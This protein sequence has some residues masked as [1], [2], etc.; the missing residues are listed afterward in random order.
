MPYLRN[1]IAY[2]H[3]F[4]YIGVKWWY[5]QAFFLV[6][7]VKGQKNGPIVRHALYLKNYTSYDLMIR[8][9]SGVK[10]QKM[11]NHTLFD[12]ISGTHV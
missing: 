10:G 7:G 3:D 9:A 5:L 2:D 4:W 1:S 8:V 6:S 11:N 12:V